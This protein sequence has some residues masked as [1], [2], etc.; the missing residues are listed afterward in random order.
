MHMTFIIG[1][2]KNEHYVNESDQ[3]KIFKNIGFKIG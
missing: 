2:Y 3:I 1:R